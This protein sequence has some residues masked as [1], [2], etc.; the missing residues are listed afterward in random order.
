[1]ISELNVDE[2]R[3]LV[4]IVW[5]GRGDF[6]ASDWLT[7]LEQAHERAQGPTAR[8]LLGMPMLADYIDAGM[9]TL[10]L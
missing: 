7:A 10:G 3:E 4:A 8:Y 6:A 9:D 5:I 2:A 1:M